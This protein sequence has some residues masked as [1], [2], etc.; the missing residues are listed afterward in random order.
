MLVMRYRGH[1]YALAPSK[2]LLEGD[3]KTMVEIQLEHISI[4]HPSWRKSLH[5]NI[6]SPN[7]CESLLVY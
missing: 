7:P 4:C 1:C 2:A 5:T 6:Q 3:M